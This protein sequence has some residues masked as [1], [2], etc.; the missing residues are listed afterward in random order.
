MARPTRTRNSLVLA[1][2]AALFFGTT[3]PSYAH[4]DHPDDDDL[5][6]V[7]NGLNMPRGVASVGKGMTLVTEGD[8]TFSIVLEQRH[9][10]PRTIELG[11][12]PGGGV[13]P[14]ID[15]GPHGMVY[16]LTGAAGGPE[17]SEMSL[18]GGSPAPSTGA[19]TLFK[20]RPGWSS[21]RPMADIGAYQARDLDPYDLEDNPG[22]SNP[23]GVHALDDGSVLVADAAGN[24]LLRVFRNGYIKT[25][26]RFKPRAVRAPAPAASSSSRGGSHGSWVLSESVP[27]SVTVG[28][29]G[30]WYVAELRG[31]PGTP[32]T[33]QVWRIKPGS[34]R[35]TCDPR[36]ATRG[37][38]Q[39]Y[40][41]G[42]TSIVDLTA[43]DNGS[44]YALSLSKMGWPAL[45]SG[46]DGAQTGALF[47]IRRHGST[48]RHHHSNRKASWERDWDG[49][50][51]W[52][53]D[54][55]RDDCDDD[56]RGGRGPWNGRDGQNGTADETT[57]E[58]TLALSRRGGRDHDECDDDHGRPRPGGHWDDCDDDRGHHGRADNV[59]SRGGNDDRR[60]GRDRDRCD[61][62]RGHHH[63]GGYGH[64]GGRDWDDQGERW[65]N[66]N[67]SHG[68]KHHNRDGEIGDLAER[69]SASVSR[70]GSRY[71][72]RHGW[73]RDK[74][75]RF[76]VT[77][78]EVVELEMPGGVDASDRGTIYL[79]GPMMSPEGSL[80]KIQD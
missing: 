56:G 40:A 66:W 32:G 49:Y 69:V 17:E 26:A 39:R 33:S 41:D 4:N 10:A 35:A 42:L 65:G 48:R 30:Y 7:T 27:T 46:V 54:H 67:D 76:R 72:N 22:E 71:D 2:S 20:W 45:E 80:M 77:I 38:C 16:I 34:H 61:G 23:F 63:G 6:T 62:D 70:H 57:T 24:D 73:R 29:D 51:Q 78:R 1:A 3:A 52:D 15:V 55:G 19:A 36:R 47:E 74:G 64:H 12:L 18:Q 50:W 43:G 28:S 9:G 53:R 14:S 37:D 8:G 75:S 5:S 59:V 68:W 11:Q 25:V 31:A 60:R 58:N 44:L 21:A 79:V 13:A